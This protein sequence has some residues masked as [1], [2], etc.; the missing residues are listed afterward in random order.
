MGSNGSRSSTGSGMKWKVVVGTGNEIKW[1]EVGQWKSW[2][3]L[4]GRE[5]AK[6]EKWDQTKRRRVQARE[7][8]VSR[9]TRKCRN[10][11]R[12]KSVRLSR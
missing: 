8:E 2:D 12:E 10:K 6:R 1:K 3:R 9:V 5:W 11:A 7:A 4:K